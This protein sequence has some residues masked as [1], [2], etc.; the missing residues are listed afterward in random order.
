MAT[1]FSSGPRHA[2]HRLACGYQPRPA[3]ASTAVTTAGVALL[4]R[5]VGR[6]VAAGLVLRAGLVE[7]GLEMRWECRVVADFEGRS[8]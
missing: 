8:G 5:A 2:Q 6:L 4:E 7:A 3:S 1:S